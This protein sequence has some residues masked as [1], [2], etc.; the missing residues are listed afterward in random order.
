MCNLNPSNI[1]LYFNLLFYVR[2]L[3]QLHG[4]IISN[5]ILDIKDELQ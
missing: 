3:S 2:T 4:F 5:K 1:F